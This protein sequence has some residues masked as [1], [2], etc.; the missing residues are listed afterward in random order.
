MIY[1]AVFFI[2][3]IAAFKY[4]P[5]FPVSIIA[6]CI[7]LMSVLFFRHKKNRKHVLFLILAILSGLFYSSV[8]HDE[9]PELSFPSEDLHVAGDVA[10]IPERS[11]EKLRFTLDRIVVEGRKIR[12]KVR[13]S[14]YK[15]YSGMPLSEIDLSPG[16]RISASA[17]LRRP[18]GFRNP[19]VYSHDLKTD[20]IVAVGYVKHM[21]IMNGRRS[22]HTRI[23]MMRQKLAAIIENSLSRES[24]SLHKALIPGLKSGISLEM[25]DAFSATGLAHLLSISGTHFGLLAFIFFQTIRKIAVCLPEKTLTRVTLYIT[26]TQA[27]ILCTLPVLVTYAY[28]SGM[29]TP[30]VRSLIMV[31]I[32]MLAL[33]LGRRGEWLNSLS[34][35]AMIILTHRPETLFELSFALSFIAVFSIGYFLENRPRTTEEQNAGS[36]SPSARTGGVKWIFLKVKTGLLLTTAAVFGTAPLSIAVFH[37]FPM[38]APLA[39]LIVTPLVCFVILPLAFVSG[40]IALFLDMQVMPINSIIDT[41]TGFALLLVKLFSS[42]PYANVRLHSPSLLLI[43]A[44]YLSWLLYLKNSCRWR[45][46]PLTIIIFLY[47][48]IPSL[49][50]HNFR[51]TFLDV[52]QGDAAVVEFPDNTV[53][54]IDGGSEDTGAGQR[55]VA[56]FLWSRGIRTIDYLVV[57]H[58]HPD[59]YGGLYYIMD[60][61]KIGELWAARTSADAAPDFFDSAAS[62]GIAVRTPV[63]GDIMKAKEYMIYALHPYD[64]FLPG[65]PRGDFS[66]ENSHS[67]VLKI[68]S[69]GTSLLFTGDIEEEAEMNLLDLG[70]WL[71]SEIIKVPHHGGRTSSSSSFLKAVNPDIAAISAGKQNPFHHPHQQTLK[72]YEKVGA[73]LLRTDRDGAITLTARDGSYKVTTYQDNR[74]QKAKGP[75]DEIRNLGLL[76]F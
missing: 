9:L 43:A 59:H 60:N 13:L 72:R 47:L 17:R 70:K 28:I 64:E 30:T 46:I 32:Y 41:I 73:R 67:L 26:P 35:A 6:S 51:I 1:L 50:N 29:S 42:I 39:N 66:D 12:G 68:E 23:L 54:L 31:L 71:E 65:S 16:K 33:F 57:S 76:L 25:R 52:G 2:A 75:G 20:G 18:A 62:K 22:A 14:V 61:F 21:T 63:R 11:E 69:H 53:M 27:A 3:G 74:F 56:P 24:G 5:Y 40:F 19:G 15:E 49:S 48:V 37:Q 38:I 34:I 8:R 44:Y 4:F 7:T 55:A 45:F 36:Y 58:P 10:D